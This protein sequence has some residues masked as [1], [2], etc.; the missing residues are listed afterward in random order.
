MHIYNGLL[1]QKRILFVGFDCSAG[2]VCEYVLSTCSLICP[3]LTGLV[4]KAFPYTNL[5]YLDFLSVYVYII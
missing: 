2:E 4:K 3:P 5:T 1:S